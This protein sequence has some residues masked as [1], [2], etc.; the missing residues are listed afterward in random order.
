[1]RG[2]DPSDEFIKRFTDDSLSVKRRSALAKS[3]ATSEFIDNESGESAALLSIDKL[4]VLEEG[5][6]EVEG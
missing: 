6:A 2:N 4:R 1:V 3:E 5:K